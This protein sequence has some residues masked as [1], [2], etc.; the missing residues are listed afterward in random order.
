[1]TLDTDWPDTDTAMPPPWSPPAVGLAAVP[2]GAYVASDAW[3]DHLDWSAGAKGKPKIINHHVNAVTAILGHSAW[4]LADGTHRI[5]YDEHSARTLVTNPPWID[6]E[7]HGRVGV[8]VEWSDSDS[9]R[10]SSW[11]LREVYQLNLS[12]EQC[13]MAVELV[14][15]QNSV[16]PFRDWLDSLVWD[17]HARLDDYL[18]EYLGC[19]PGEYASMVGPWWL[20]SAVAR[21]YRP[22]CKA[23]YVLVLE[24]PQGALK[25]TFLR[26]LAG[27]RYFSDT[28]I[29][30]GNKDAFIAIQGLVIVEMAEFESVG[31]VQD[32]RAKAFFSSPEDNYRQPYGRRNIRVP[33]GCIFG[34]TINP[35]GPYLTDPTGARRYW[36]VRCGTIDIAGLAAVREQL[37]AEA[38]ARFNSG[39][40]WW[41]DTADEHASCAWEQGKRTAV[42]A[43]REP[44]RGWLVRQADMVTLME[45]AKGALGLEA[46]D[47]SRQT[48]GRIATILAG[49]GWEASG[50]GWVRRQG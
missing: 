46:R 25:S 10:L 48:E 7:R 13:S 22:G 17:G 21:T 8:Q 15:A 34:A 36:P 6:T 32:R 40:R 30:I 47:V 33:R 24:G 42:D 44:V 28:P 16:H 4:R 9:G 29:D 35:H 50:E 5:Q 27:S 11:L 1:M 3:K 37:W 18:P 14:A 12:A 49:I 2:K 23:D 20:M 26:T 45:V 43:W 19:E 38:V 39:A 41:P 31:R